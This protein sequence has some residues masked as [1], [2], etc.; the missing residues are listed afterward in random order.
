MV[1]YAEQEE[2]WIPQDAEDAW[3]SPYSGWRDLFK[4]RLEA[5]GSAGLDG[6]YIDATS[7]PGTDVFGEFWASSDPSFAAAFKARYG[8]DVPTTIDWDSVNWRKFIYFRH[9]AVRDYLSDLANTARE[10]GMTPFFEMSSLDNETGTALGNDNQFTINGGIAVSPEVEPQYL[11]GG[12]LEAFRGAKASRD[13]NPNFPLWFLGWPETATNAHKEFAITLALSGNYYPTSDAPYPAN[14]FAFIDSLRVP[15]LDKRQPYFN[16]ALL[17]PMRSKDFTYPTGS[18]LAD[19]ANAFTTLAEKH[20]PFRILPQD[21]MT[22][23]DLANIS[24]VVLAGAESMTDAEYALLQDKTVALV[25]QNGTKDMWF[26]PHAR[27]FNPTVPIESLMPTLPFTITAPTSTYTEYYTDRNNPSHFFIFAY[28]DTPSG[29]ITI[30][31]PVT[32]T[33]EIY[34]LDQPVAEKSGTS[35]TLNIS[36]YLHIIDLIP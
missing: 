30:S 2:D 6:V 4:R 27:S 16:T 17:Y 3:A 28:N 29:Q 8:V 35:I 18:A 10:N 24:T 23:A 31:Q 1:F 22:E 25:G 33:A 11:E 34:T 7:L 9:E 15:I 20:I 32:L 12:F 21:T 36:D 19:Y 14:A 5:L 26:Q 13:A